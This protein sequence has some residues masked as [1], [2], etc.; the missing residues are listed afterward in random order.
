MSTHQVRCIN[1]RGDRYDA[2]ERI[3]HI[4]GLNDNGSRWKLAQED[5]IKS[6]EKNEYQFYVSVNGKSVK[7][8]VA[9]HNSRKYLRTESDDYS[10]NNLLSL[11]ECP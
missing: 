6:I 10:S 8:V 7:V 1:K 4:G 11:P 2:H 3:S 9:E 5:A